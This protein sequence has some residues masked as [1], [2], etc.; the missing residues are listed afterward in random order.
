MEDVKI[1]GYVDVLA[2]EFGRINEKEII[3]PGPFIPATKEN[4]FLWKSVLSQIHDLISSHGL[5]MPPQTD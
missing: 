5:F 3:I 4:R 1:I 2:T